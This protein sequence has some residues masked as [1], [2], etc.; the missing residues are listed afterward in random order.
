MQALIQR[1][2]PVGRLLHERAQE[3]V[4]HGHARA[5]HGRSHDRGD[6]LEQ[7]Q[8]VLRWGANSVVAHE[9]PAMADAI[10]DE[11]HPDVA[12][13]P[14]S[15]SHLRHGRGA[16]GHVLDDLGRRGRRVGPRSLA[17]VDAGHTRPHRHVDGL[18]CARGPRA[19]EDPEALAAV[20]LDEHGGAMEGHD[21][22]QRGPD[23]REH[24]LV[25]ASDA[26]EDGPHRRLDDGLF[27]WRQTGHPGA[28]PVH[29]GQDEG[30]G[31]GRLRLLLD[32]ERSANALLQVGRGA[33]RE[34]AGDG[35]SL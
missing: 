15:A 35:L 6:A 13:Q 27:G 9:P 10:V 4:A 8:R 34:E 23:G 21:L 30:W 3:R 5:R 1:E 32:G 11:R 20:L 24:V 7:R 17:P 26:P 14:R 16:H 22:L 25:E 28:L 19:P 12:E 33:G 18:G 31:H 2:H 29:P